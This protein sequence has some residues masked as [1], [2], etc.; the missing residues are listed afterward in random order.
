MSWED[1]LKTGRG[2]GK[3]SQRAREFLDEL[4]SDKKPRTDRE[5]LDDLWTK[6]EEMNAERDTMR[7]PTHQLRTG[8]QLIPTTAKIREY[9][10]KDAKYESAI[11]DIR[12][13]KILAVKGKPYH[14]K[15]YW[16]K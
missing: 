6:I 3:F 4:M 14:K 8:A 15:K 13:N 2:K 10:S 7:T 16:M 12:T 5:I 11:Y 1:I 9:L